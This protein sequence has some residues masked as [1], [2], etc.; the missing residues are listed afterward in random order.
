MDLTE[1]LANTSSPII[2]KK[3]CS[4]SS[5]RLSYTES[6]WTPL[7]V[8]VRQ[9]KKNRIQVQFDAELCS[10]KQ[11][12]NPPDIQLKQNDKIMLS[13]R[14]LKDHEMNNIDLLLQLH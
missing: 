12:K 2:E 6:L 10:K 1:G 4:S 8:I 11:T 14:H 7:S 9:G 5:K 13:K 3:L